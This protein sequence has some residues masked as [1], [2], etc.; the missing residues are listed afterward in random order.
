MREVL[1]GCPVR[2]CAGGDHRVTSPLRAISGSP[3]TGRATP[4]RPRVAPPRF[5]VGQPCGW[6]V[7]GV[8]GAGCGGWRATTPRAGC[9]ARALG[10][11]AP[12]LSVCLP[13]CRSVTGCGGASHRLAHAGGLLAHFGK[14]DLRRFLRQAP[15]LTAPGV[16]RCTRSDEPLCADRAPSRRLIVLDEHVRLRRIIHITHRPRIGGRECRNAD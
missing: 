15:P 4:T 3:P 9:S 5:P 13:V 11:L 16:E 2:A 1:L 14:G 12:S 8:R 7:G 6:W 10:P